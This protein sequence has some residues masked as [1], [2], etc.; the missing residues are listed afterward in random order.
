MLPTG[1]MSHQTTGRATREKIVAVKLIVVI[2]I[3][4][5]YDHRR[6]RQKNGHNMLQVYWL[7]VQFRD[8]SV[9]NCPSESDQQSPDDRK[10]SEAGRLKFL[11]SPAGERTLA[12]LLPYSNVCST[13]RHGLSGPAYVSE[14]LPRSAA[15]RSL[16]SLVS[17]ALELLPVESFQYFCV[18]RA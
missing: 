15:R 16:S 17:W 5:R 3:F 1:K 10:V 18:T 2:A 4:F 11:I 8:M 6:C 7:L 14:Y 13:S 9:S 12:T